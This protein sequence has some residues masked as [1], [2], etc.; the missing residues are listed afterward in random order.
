LGIAVTSLTF[1]H[2]YLRWLLAMI[3]V[4]ILAGVVLSACNSQQPAPSPTAIPAD[5]P[6]LQP[7][8]PISPTLTPTPEQPVMILLPAPESDPNLVDVLQT[9]LS[10]FSTQEGLRF[11]LRQQVSPSDLGNGV[12]LVVVIAPDPGLAELVAAAPQVQFLTIGIPD[13]E[14]STN[15]SSVSAGETSPDQLGFAAGYLAATITDDWRV[16]VVSEA[17]TVA[18]KAA[19][20]GFTSGVYFLCGLCRPVNPPYPIPG[21]PLTAQLFPGAGQAEW[22]AAVNYFQEWQVGTVYVGPGVADPGLLRE[23]ADAGIQMIGAQA[24][25]ADVKSNWVASVGYGDP[26]EAINML[27]PALLDGQGGQQIQLPVALSNVNADLLSPG[28]QRLVEEMLDDLAAGYI[29]TGVDP[30]TGESRY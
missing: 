26:L 23:L 17:D 22:Q 3:L 18:G 7:L 21:Y 24:P 27:L 1:F 20:L 16:G 14:P 13:I 8:Q 9:R 19:E 29:D 4:L 30:Q 10:E 6:T 11:E 5:N 28:R 15:L 2:R 12:R 25:P